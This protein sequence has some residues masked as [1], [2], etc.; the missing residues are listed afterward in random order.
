MRL[1]TLLVV[2]GKSAIAALEYANR[3]IT[4]TSRGLGIDSACFFSTLSVLDEGDRMSDVLCVRD[5]RRRW[6]PHKERL[7][8][9]GSGHT[10][11][12]RFHRSCSW[13]AR[14]ETMPESDDADLALVSLWIA[15]NSLYGQWDK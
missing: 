13:L 8:A 7:S 14:V 10:T 2:A 15:F 9:D 5:L 6:K 4:I 1:G 12:V 3:H 11:P